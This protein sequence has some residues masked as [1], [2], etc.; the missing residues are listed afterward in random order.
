[1]NVVQSRDVKIH[2][3]LFFEQENVMRQPLQV[4]FAYND[5]ILCF[6]CYNLLIL[7]V[8]LKPY[9]LL[10]QAGFLSLHMQ[11]LCIGPF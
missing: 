1:M 5:G 6:Q 8:E 4:T 2:G 11:N 10:G 9:E 7:H 3:Y